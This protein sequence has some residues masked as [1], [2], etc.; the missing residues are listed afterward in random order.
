MGPG[1]GT[2]RIVAAA[3]LIALLAGCS[4]GAEEPDAAP[5]PSTAS[6]A[7]APVDTG[8][9]AR[10]WL[11]DIPDLASQIAIEL[12]TDGLEVTEYTGIG[13]HT[14]TF[15]E[16]GEASASVDVTFALTATSGAG[17]EITVV[18][19]HT[20]EPG[21]LWGWVGDTNVME[22]ADWDDGGYEVQN[23]TAI[24]GVTTE[25]PIALPSDPLVGTTMDVVCDRSTMS[26]HQTSSPYTLHWTEER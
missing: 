25:G 11:L 6:P 23:I 9:I 12:S 24:G 5:A 21:G 13:R 10:T 22:F 17:P 1:T 14:F 7:A 2:T 4:P 8:C 19:I 20:G 18:Q 3:A 26:T 15:T 16:A